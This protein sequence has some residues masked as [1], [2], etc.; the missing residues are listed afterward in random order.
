MNSRSITV[1]PV[2]TAEH[3]SA[4]GRSSMHIYRGGEELGITQRP[5]NCNARD[6]RVY[7]PMVR[8]RRTV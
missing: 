7:S 8:M 3:Y 4:N 5:A 6:G 2:A 1:N